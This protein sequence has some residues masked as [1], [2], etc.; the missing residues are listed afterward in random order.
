M[1]LTTD[2]VLYTA[3]SPHQ[4]WPTVSLVALMA[5]WNIKLSSPSWHHRWRHQSGAVVRR[6]GL[7]ACFLR[8]YGRL[9]TVP[10]DEDSPPLP[11]DAAIDAEWIVL[12]AA[13]SLPP[14]FLASTSVCRAWN[15]TSPK[16]GE[17]HTRHV[18][19]SKAT[20]GNIDGSAINGGLS[21]TN[22]RQ[23]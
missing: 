20:R 1:S 19:Y 7:S 17:P 9:Q 5:V 11:T 21:G 10:Q 23:S 6:R 14:S 18:R 13:A 22:H 12:M 2:K 15:A 8:C 16:F 4:G 3:Q